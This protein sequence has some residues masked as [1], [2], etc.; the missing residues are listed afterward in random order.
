MGVLE[1]H[2][3]SARPCSPRKPA[4]TGQCSHGGEP[5]EGAE[6]PSARPP[7]AGCPGPVPSTASCVLGTSLHQGAAAPPP[8]RGSG[9]AINKGLSDAARH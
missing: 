6:H 2:G 8:L 9:R 7:P 4:G 5:S 3:T 1:A